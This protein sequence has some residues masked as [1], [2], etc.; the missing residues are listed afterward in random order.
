MKAL[1]W[2]IGLIFVVSAW[3]SADQLIIDFTEPTS[4]LTAI[5]GGT[6]NSNTGANGMEV[7]GG[8]KGYD[9]NGL[10]WCDLSS[11]ALATIN[12]ATFHVAQDGWGW[13][14]CDNVEVRRFTSTQNWVPGDGTW[15][16]RWT[17]DN[18]CGWRMSDWYEDNVGGSGHD[19]GGGFH[20][21]LAGD[22][23]LNLWVDAAVWDCE[24]IPA[25]GAGVDFD[26]TAL[27]QAWADGTHPNNGWVMWTGNAIGSTS[28]HLSGPTLT[29]NY[30]P[31]PEPATVLLLGTAAIALLGLARR[32][33]MR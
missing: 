27:V 11:L 33:R 22:N 18:G 3:A 17:N 13:S 2:T 12:T 5:F 16:D 14:G 8:P 23:M 29:I 6:Q 31:I 25:G 10:L 19:W 4:K 26:M 1:V 32:P 7:L 9:M 28:A 24:H 20:T 30:T 15:A 21:W